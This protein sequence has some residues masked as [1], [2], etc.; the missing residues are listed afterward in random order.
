MLIAAR[1]IPVPAARA[2]QYW[3]AATRNQH[4]ATASA[5]GLIVAPDHRSNVC[6]MKTGRLWQRMHLWATSQG[7][8]MQPLNQPIERAER[9][10][11]IGLAPRFGNALNELIGDRRWQPLMAFRIGYP[12]KDPGVSPRRSL[13]DVVV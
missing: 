2:D 10:E 5:F 13:Q 12:T 11:S 8:A 3:L 4:V 6:R 1:L 7:L 9:E